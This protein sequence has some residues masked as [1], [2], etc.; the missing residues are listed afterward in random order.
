MGLS[1]GPDTGN[2]YFGKWVEVI[3]NRLPSTSVTDTHDGEGCVAE[4]PVIG[5]DNPELQDTSHMG[6]LNP[7]LSNITRISHA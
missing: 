3:T 2:M 5:P 1:L 7:R 4:P 6:S